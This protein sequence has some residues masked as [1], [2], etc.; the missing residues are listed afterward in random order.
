MGS[1]GR[2][3]DGGSEVRFAFGADGREEGGGGGQSRSPVRAGEGPGRGCASPPHPPAA[4]LRPGA[5]GRR[6][7]RGYLAAKSPAANEP[8]AALLFLAAAPRDA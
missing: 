3:K 2:I 1:Q 4:W 6:A 8:G 5:S 7:G